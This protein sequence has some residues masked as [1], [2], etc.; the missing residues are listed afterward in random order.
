MPGAGEDDGR[1]LGRGGLRWWVPAGAPARSRK[2]RRSGGHSD[3]RRVPCTATRTRSGDVSVIRLP[4]A[5][6]DDVRDRAVR[7]FTFLREY[8][9]LRARTVLTTDGYDKVILLADVPSLPG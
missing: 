4:S 8:T 9:Q 6:P 5:A 2:G 7:L 3:V 1:G